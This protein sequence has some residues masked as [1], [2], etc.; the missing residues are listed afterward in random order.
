M[1]LKHLHVTFK[2]GLINP[3]RNL[4]DGAETVQLVNFPLWWQTCPQNLVQVAENTQR[5]LF[6]LWLHQP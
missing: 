2:R 1:V 3:A 5:T 4:R 6:Q